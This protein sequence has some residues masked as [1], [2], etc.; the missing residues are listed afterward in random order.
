VVLQFLPTQGTA[1]FDETTDFS[2]VEFFNFGLFRTVRLKLKLHTT[3][4]GGV[5]NLCGVYARSKLKD[6]AAK[7]GGLA[8]FF[9]Q[10]LPLVG[11]D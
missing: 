10:S 2:R 8:F 4:V 7:A 3:K 9:A 1:A 6:H 5:W 11:F